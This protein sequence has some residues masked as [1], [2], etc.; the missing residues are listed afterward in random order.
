MLLLLLLLLLAMH[1]ACLHGTAQ[2][3]CLVLWLP[4]IRRQ[5]LQTRCLLGR[6]EGSPRSA[7]KTP[8]ILQTP[9]WRH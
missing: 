2:V 6:R 5:M 1:R 4:L 8:S 3:L 9:E 7:V